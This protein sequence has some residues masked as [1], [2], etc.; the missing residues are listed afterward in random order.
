MP[1]IPALPSSR[2]THT[3]TEAAGRPV[4][5]RAR[6]TF[7]LLARTGS[8]PNLQSTYQFL[9]QTTFDHHLDPTTDGRDAFGDEGCPAPRRSPEHDSRMERPGPPPLLPDQHPRRPA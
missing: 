4:P 3:A 7:V 9:Q 2:P 8:L 6:G 5:A 1:S